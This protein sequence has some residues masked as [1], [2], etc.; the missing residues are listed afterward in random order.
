M[1]LLCVS[2]Y[3]FDMSGEQL[4]ENVLFL[5]FKALYKLLSEVNFSY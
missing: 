3:L 1:I 4:A 2:I 5:L